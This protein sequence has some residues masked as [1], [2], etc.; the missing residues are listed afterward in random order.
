MAYSNLSILITLSMYN[1]NII[2]FLYL[3]VLT[4]LRKEKYIKVTVIFH[5]DNIYSF[6]IGIN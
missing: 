5:Y 6:K 1:K 3:K 4:V 2:S